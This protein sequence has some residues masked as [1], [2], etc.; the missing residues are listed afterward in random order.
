MASLSLAAACPSR[1]ATRQTPIG[2]MVTPSS[3]HARRA[4]NG[5]GATDASTASI[6]AREP[7]MRPGSTP[8]KSRRGRLSLPQAGQR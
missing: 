1:C 6:R 2:L 3:N 7:L 5:Y 4:A 8:S